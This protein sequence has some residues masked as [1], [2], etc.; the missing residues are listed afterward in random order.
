MKL[1]SGGRRVTKVTSQVRRIAMIRQQPRQQFVRRIESQ[2]TPAI[3]HA[4][5][6]PSAPRLLAWTFGNIPRRILW[7]PIR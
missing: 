7:R 5:A 6:C 1:E 3:S 2:E 4:F